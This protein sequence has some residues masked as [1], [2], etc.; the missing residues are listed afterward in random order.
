M[1][2]EI[3]PLTGL[4]G[5]AA[6]WVVVYHV[7]EFD[8]VG[9]PFAPLLKHGYLAVDVFFILSGFVMALS[10]QPLFAAGFTG[11]N[12]ATF[13]LRRVARIYPLYAVLTGIIVFLMLRHL[14]S[15]IELEQILARFAFNVT[16][17]DAWGLSSPFDG[18]A[19]SISTE[20]G[21]YLL[22]PLLAVA[23][24]YRSDRSALIT[25]FV[26]ALI[27]SALAL[28]PTPRADIGL[29]QGPLDLFWG[30]T[31]WPLLR[32]ITEFSTGLIAYR[33]AKDPGVQRIC[34]S[35]A[36]AVIVGSPVSGFCWCPA[37]IWPSWCWCRA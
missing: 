8:Q 22:F 6:C 13:L 21:A 24:L 37:P 26:C 35:N 9:G 19:W 29:R 32:C 14:G 7:H 4:R 25:A 36:F 12:Y 28:L 27:L 15:R 5:V 31:A 30:G 10:Y 17:T 34:G 2:K 16:L 18:P 33:F 23:T 1:R 20:F 11:R 3:A